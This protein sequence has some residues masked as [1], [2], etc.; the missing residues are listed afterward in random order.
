MD[1]KSL[2]EIGRT[3]CVCSVAMKLQELI[4]SDG[5]TLGQGKPSERKLAS[6]FSVS[7]GV[8][9]TALKSLVADGVIESK[10]NCRPVVKTKR[11]FGPGKKQIVIWLWSNS[12][13]FAG[14]ILKGIQGSD[15]ADD[16]R[17]VVGNAP[18]GSIASVFEAEEGFLRS[19]A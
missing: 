12:A 9:R 18:T 13:D 7:R 3:P 2:A 14:S 19:V 1:R 15:L 4:R 8:V 11:A 6:D 17:L 5:L 10:W 16:A